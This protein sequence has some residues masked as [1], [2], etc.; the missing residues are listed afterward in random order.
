MVE[1]MRNPVVTVGRNA[2]RFMTA[3]GQVTILLF[4]TLVAFRKI[5]TYLPQIV[6]QYSNIERRSRPLVIVAASAMGFILGIQIGT[7]MDAATP[8]WY[9]GGLILRSVLLEMGP[10][11]M[12]L[13]LSGRVGSGIAAE[14]GAMQVTE[15]ID[16]LRVMAVDP[17]E[18]LV[19]PRIVAGLVA[20]P[21]LVIFA[22]LV[23]ILSGYVSAYFTI[24]LSWDGFMKGMTRAF[25]ITDVFA[26]LI[27]STI[28]GV[29][30]IL[31]G[32]FFGMTAKRGA[33][34]VGSSTTLAFV[35]SSVA[36][37]VLDYVI[38]AV[39]FFIW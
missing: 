38:S 2:A 30:F 20:V 26:S 21:V 36:I 34:G 22:E 13:V 27:K 12:A 28:F 37:L 16:A 39:L 23:A 25:A 29:V 17:V 5:P 8:K 11:I 6:E 33:K 31:F 32:C 3:Y 4:Q 7:Q 19:M 18:F 14:L 35:W 24:H 15:Q 9:E 1:R 10:L